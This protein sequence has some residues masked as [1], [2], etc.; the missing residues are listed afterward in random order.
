[1]TPAQYRTRW[2]LPADYPMVAPNYA[3]V[4]SSLAKKIGLGRKRA[5]PTTRAPAKRPGP[6]VAAQRGRRARAG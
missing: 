3:K 1:M 4:R 5:A 6:K 2:G